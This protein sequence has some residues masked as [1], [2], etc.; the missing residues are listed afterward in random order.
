[1]KTIFKITLSV[2]T[3]LF[4]SCSN[5]DDTTNTETPQP[6][7]KLTS[8]T[9]SQGVTNTTTTFAYNA[10]GRWTSGVNRFN[11]NY[12][13]SY[14]VDGKITAYEVENTTPITYE[15][16]VNGGAFNGILAD[17]YETDVVYNNFK[18]TGL[19]FYDG[20]LANT[21]DITYDANGNIETIT[22]NDES[23]RNK[24]IY[25]TQNRIIRVEEYSASN[26]TAPYELY[27][28]TDYE[29]E[30]HKSPVYAFFKTQLDLGQLIF[31]PVDI[32]PFYSRLFSYSD[33]GYN[34]YI[35]PE[36]HIKTLKKYNTINTTSPVFEVFMNY[37]LENNQV[38]SFTTT[39]VYNGTTNSETTSYT[40]E[41]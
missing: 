10:Q 21:F 9:S 35:L 40:Y 23:I 31:S 13:V 38:T 22:N 1:M 7:S 26:P 28:Y 19:D 6:E 33:F 15:Y 4:L 27:T 17:T 2:L 11:Q 25:D 18:I 8:I 41:N 24:F 29:Y 34:L 39:S 14:N 30:E 20:S 16:S 12:T 36:Y 5:D 37:T 3:I 32:Y